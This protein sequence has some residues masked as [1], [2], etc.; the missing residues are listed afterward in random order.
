MPTNTKNESAKDGTWMSTY[1]VPCNPSYAIGALVVGHHVL[2]ITSALGVKKVF[3]GNAGRV[4]MPT[5]VYV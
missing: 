4:G 3:E 5:N 2:V 1:V